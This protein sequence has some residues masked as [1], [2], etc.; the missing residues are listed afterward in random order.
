MNGPSV[1]NIGLMDAIRR[2]HISGFT[3]PHRTTFSHAAQ[4]LPI[5]NAILLVHPIVANP[6]EPTINRNRSSHDPWVQRLL[7]ICVICCGT[8]F[9]ARKV[10]RAQARTCMF[11]GLRVAFHEGGRAISQGEA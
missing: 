6:P 10:L 7:V 8:G 2:A 3:I 11:T 4:Q 9:H 5:H 1:L